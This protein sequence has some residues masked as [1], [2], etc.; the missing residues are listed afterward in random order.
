[1]YSTKDQRKF[2]ESMV[3]RRMEIESLEISDEE[4]SNLYQLLNET[5]ER[6]REGKLNHI[7]DQIASARLTKAW[8]GIGDSLAVVV[9]SGG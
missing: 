6:Y 9:S 4:R 2:D 5:I 3:I 1:M 8:G 7:N